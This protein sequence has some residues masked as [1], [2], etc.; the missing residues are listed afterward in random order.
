MG[1]L[2]IQWPRRVGKLLDCDSDPT[3]DSRPSVIDFRCSLLGTPDAICLSLVGVAI[4]HQH[5]DTPDLDP[6]YHAGTI[7]ELV[8]RIAGPRRTLQAEPSLD[9]PFGGAQIP[10]RF[11]IQADHPNVLNHRGD[12]Y[13]QNAPQAACTLV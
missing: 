4:D 2:S 7:A 8:F 12:L 3:P 9:R 11:R 5:R 10:L 1:A 13:Q 6:P